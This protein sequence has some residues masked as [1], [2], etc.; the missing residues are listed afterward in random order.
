MKKRQ[1]TMNMKAT[2][3]V[4]LVDLPKGAYRVG[5]DTR[6]AFSIKGSA[7]LA[8]CDNKGTKQGIG[9]GAYW[10]FPEFDDSEMMG[11][12]SEEQAFALYMTLRAALGDVRRQRCAF[13]DHSR[14]DHGETGCCGTPKHPHVDA[15]GDCPCNGFDRRQRQ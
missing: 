2:H 8:L 15:G 7:R 9:D 4:R 12:L 1:A 11:E 5:E 6:F 10:C 14:E 13:C 3:V